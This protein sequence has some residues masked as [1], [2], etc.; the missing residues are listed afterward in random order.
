VFLAVAHPTRADPEELEWRT[1]LAVVV[2][3]VLVVLLQG[4][5]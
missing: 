1:V 2:I 4:G 3:V 5:C